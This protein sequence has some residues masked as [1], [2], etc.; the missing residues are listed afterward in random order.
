MDDHRY[1]IGQTV[2]FVGVTQLGR[3]RMPTGDFRVVG[4]LPEYQG[5]KQYRLESTSDGHHRVAVE[6]EIHVQ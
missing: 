1:R 4:L 5:S 6:T 3:P 2:R